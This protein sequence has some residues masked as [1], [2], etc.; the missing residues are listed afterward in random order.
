MRDGDE[1]V[2]NGRKWYTTN[3]TH[4]RCEIIILMGKSDPDNADRHRQQSMIL[5][6]KDTP[7]VDVIRPLPGVQLLRDARPGLRGPVHRC[8]RAGH[9]HAAGRGARV[10]DRPGPPRA[11]P[12][13]P[14]HATDRTGR[15]RARDDV[16]THATP[17][18]VR[19][20]GRRAGR[21]ARA[22]RRVAH[23]HRADPPVDPEDRAPDGHGRQQGSAARDRDDQDRR[24]EHGLQGRR[25]GDPGLR[26]RRHE[27]RLRP[28]GDVRHRAPAPARRRSGRGPPQPARQRSNS[29]DMPARAR[30]SHTPPRHRR[31][32]DSQSTFA[33]G[34][35]GTPSP[36]FADTN[37]GQARSS[38]RAGGEWGVASTLTW[39]RSTSPRLGA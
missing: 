12:H 10:R 34:F 22:H 5:V 38:G 25:L 14:L 24:P 30:S 7:G 18:D 3:A 1:Y 21:D 15:T 29:G 28:G 16:S 27:Q 19:P 11:G 8:P 17:G 23:R 13:P 37:D 32:P 20:P 9:Q 33:S 4:P 39:R 6:P 31:G 36:L 2:I 35:S 26:R